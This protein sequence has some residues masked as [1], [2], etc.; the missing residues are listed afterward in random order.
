VDALP[1]VAELARTSASSTDKVLALRGMIRL[2][3]L[4]DRRDETSVPLLKEA[5]DL[6]ERDEEKQLALSAL[7]DIPRL[8]ALAVAQAYLDDPTLAEEAAQACVAIA[9][10]IAKTHP[11]EV[12]KVMRHVANSTSDKKLAARARK[13]SR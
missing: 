11:E 3:A 12:A 1:A 2:S 5:L 7:G 4:Q 13:L 9:E 10:K 6:A 8:K